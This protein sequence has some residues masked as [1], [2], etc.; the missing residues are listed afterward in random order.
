MAGDASGEPVI[1]VEDLVRDYQRPRTSLTRPGQ[2]VHALRG[3]SFQVA[4]GERF[5]IVGE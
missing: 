2:T 3:V 4:A 5:G 1:V